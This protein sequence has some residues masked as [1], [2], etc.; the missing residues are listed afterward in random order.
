MLLCIVI[1]AGATGHADAK[2]TSCP[3]SSSDGCCNTGQAGLRLGDLAQRNLA[4]LQCVT[5]DCTICTQQDASKVAQAALAQNQLDAFARYF[6]QWGCW[7]GVIAESAGGVTTGL[8]PRN[9][10]ASRMACSSCNTS[11]IAT[12]KIS[13]CQALVPI[14][15]NL[16]NRVSRATLDSFWSIVADMTTCPCEFCASNSKQ[17]GDSNQVI[18]NVTIQAFE[19]TPP[20]LC[21]DKPVAFEASD[22]PDQA[23]SKSAMARLMTCGGSCSTAAM[24][25]P[26]P[27]ISCA[28]AESGLF[29][30]TTVIVLGIA[31]G[32]LA[33]VLAV[34]VFRYY[35]RR[36]GAAPVGST[37]YQELSSA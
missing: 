8:A 33:L 9:T 18:L 7:E 17:Q 27:D 23:P 13:S 25:S 29:T 34:G 3:L 20:L 11:V 10:F 31:V 19:Y 36:R 22:D 4:M 1:L 28:S 15:T 2:A 37:A 24:S 26:I 30:P 35:R 14:C 12:A 32:V 6:D 21:W 5:R 16:W